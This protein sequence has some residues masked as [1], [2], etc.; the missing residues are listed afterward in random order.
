MFLDWMY[1][2]SGEH[3]GL[4]FPSTPLFDAAVSLSELCQHKAAPQPRT[5]VHG[6]NVQRS[7][8]RNQ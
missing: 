5:Q 1:F 8:N 2:V 4:Q 7:D 6:G 3:V